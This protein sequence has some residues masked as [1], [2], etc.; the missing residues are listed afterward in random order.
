MQSAMGQGQSEDSPPRSSLARVLV[1]YLIA[2]GAFEGTAQLASSMDLAWKQIAIAVA[3]VVA[4][5]AAEILLFRRSPRQALTWLGLGRPSRWSIVVSAALSLLL[6][7]AYPI[8]ARVTGAQF[9]LATNW[10]VLALGIFL[11]NGIAEE[12]IYRGYL[13][14][15]LRQGRTFR[16][17]VL[18]GIVLH[19]AAHLPI[20]AIAG[21]VVGLSAVLVAVLTFLPYAALFE[22]GR[23]TVWAPALLHFASDTI[24]LLIGAGALADP[25]VQVATLLWL[26]VIATVPYLL[27][28]IPGR[29]RSLPAP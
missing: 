19:A 23:N 9:V 7:A 12:M 25:A 15:H 1:G 18:L 20:L 5:L 28:A 22:R 6:L 2:Y 26:L 3:G 13:F 4:T 11:M 27:F 17:A 21:V 10:P 8:L 29:K 14:Q 24:K 16:R